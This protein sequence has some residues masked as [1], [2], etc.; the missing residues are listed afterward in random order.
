[1]GGNNWAER[2]ADQVRRTPPLVL[3]LLLSAIIAAAGTVYGAAQCVWDGYDETYRWRQHE[4]E[5]IA[6]LRAG[7]SIERYD[8]LLGSPLFVR[9]NDDGSLT[10]S[11]FRERDYWIQAVHDA[12]GTV[13][14][15]S[16][17]ACDE[18]FRPTF[19]IVDSRS[20]RFGV[21]LNDIPLSEVPATPDRVF[22]FLPV[23]TAN[24]YLYDEYYFGNPGLYKSYYV[25]INDACPARAINVAPFIDR[26]LFF[27]A[28]P[29]PYGTA[30]ANETPISRADF[31]AIELFRR[32]SIPNTYAEA[33]FAVSRTKQMTMDDILADFQLGVDR[34]LIRTVH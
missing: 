8:E 18:D 22:Y 11:S 26:E 1:M 19:Q 2:F 6:E 16:V 28:T 10:E 14:L 32:H 21:T 13:L 9:D 7:I 34:I 20:V 4:Y 27:R 25:G 24:M 33:F 5:K 31:I 3:L 30:Y 17:S 12:T 29:L 15:F 23:A